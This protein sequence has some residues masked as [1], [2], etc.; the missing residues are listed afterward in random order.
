MRKW[1]VPLLVLVSMLWQ[2]LATAQVGSTLPTPSEMMHS[3]L[4]WQAESHHHHEDGSWHADDS[5]E[6]S[7]HVLCDHLSSP[8]ALPHSALQA[9]L[10]DAR[11]SVHPRVL[12]GLPAPHL[13]G[14]L[15]PPRLI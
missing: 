11:S 6:S 4:H 12:S 9:H 7:Q 15:R 8:A 14:P 1:L 2:S 13:K 3:V 10:L 5:A